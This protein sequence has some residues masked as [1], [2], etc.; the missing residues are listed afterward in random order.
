MVTHVYDPVELDTCIIRLID[1]QGICDT[2]GATDAQISVE[3]LKTLDKHGINEI[4]T[5]LWTC[6][7]DSRASSFLQYTAKFIN[8]LGDNSSHAMAQNVVVLFKSM[9]RIKGVQGVLAALGQCVGG[10][11]DDY[12]Y[13]FAHILDKE[14]LD[15]DD[16]PMAPSLKLGRLT[17]DMY[18]DLLVKIVSTE[19][20]PVQVI[21]KHF[22]CTGCGI[23]TDPRLVDVYCHLDFEK[24]HLGKL[25]F[26]H[27]KDLIKRHKSAPKVHH[28]IVA[29]HRSQDTIKIHQTT[30]RAHRQLSRVHLSK[31]VKCHVPKTGLAHDSVVAQHK[32]SSRMHKQ[33]IPMTTEIKPGFSLFFPIIPPSGG[34]QKL[35]CSGC[36]KD[37]SS[38]GCVLSCC[39]GADDDK[40]MS[41][42]SHCKL[43]LS[44]PGCLPACCKSKDGTLCT[45]I[46][47]CCD[48]L[49]T[50]ADDDYA[51]NYQRSV[52]EHAK[53][54]R[55][56][57]VRC[58]AKSLSE[59]EAPNPALACVMAC[60]NGKLDAPCCKV[61]ACCKADYS[62]GAAASPCA[63]L[64]AHC[65][66]DV[67][68][69]HIGCRPS[70]CLGEMA[71]GCEKVYECCQRGEA[72]PGCSTVHSGCGHSN[73]EEPCADLCVAC[74]AVRGTKPG[75][76]HGTKEHDFVAINESGDGA[77]VALAAA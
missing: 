72:D 42:C 59:S 7:L 12:E 3:T 33:L 45:W 77:P 16:Q 32:S 21:R 36:G 25:G 11:Q 58:N 44:A 5:I 26:A 23:M 68:F 60:C 50:G 73:R 37:A 64:C 62:A 8:S 28:P 63:K 13:H 19:R 40:C 48:K 29:G 49:A 53:G 6:G 65:N 31:P 55:Q 27:P 47:P 38:K 41:I 14:D 20:K 4:H 17:A 69:D 39:G 10:A 15:D 9:K 46:F 30:A 51:E 1:T 74:K 43:D 75:C 54:C 66:M 67:D 71:D 61:Y 34:D 76:R 35:M 24:H 52:T 57:C 18:R 70:C 22:K 56:Q 2:T